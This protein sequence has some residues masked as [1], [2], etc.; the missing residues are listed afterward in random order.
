MLVEWVLAGLEDQIGEALALVLGG[1]G[2]VAS[3]DPG[4]LNP[5]LLTEI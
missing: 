1:L 5:Q 2:L 3:S 4:K